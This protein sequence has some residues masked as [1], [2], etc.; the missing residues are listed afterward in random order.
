MAYEFQSLLDL[1]EQIWTLIYL[2]LK[3]KK[4]KA[5]RYRP[6]LNLQTT[7]DNRLLEIIFRHFNLN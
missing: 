5:M 1:S 4:L 3:W 2:L 6:T 7:I